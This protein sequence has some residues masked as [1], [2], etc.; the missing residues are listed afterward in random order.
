MNIQNRIRNSLF[1]REFIMQRKQPLNSYLIFHIHLKMPEILS[2]SLIP[3]EKY[4]ESVV[5]GM[6]NYSCEMINQSWT[7]N[8]K[9]RSMW[10]KCFGKLELTISADGPENHVQRKV[11]VFSAFQ[12]RNGNENNLWVRKFNGMFRRISNHVFLYVIVNRKGGK[13]GTIEIK[14][15][16]N[17]LF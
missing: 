8:L 3:L 1:F 2:H 13:L 4:D 6:I 17:S 16:A 7:D 12:S 9:K 11:L 10:M 14:I 5:W 15:A